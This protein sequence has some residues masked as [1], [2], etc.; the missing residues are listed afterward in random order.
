[1]DAPDPGATAV[2]PPDGP[3]D[4]DRVELLFEDYRDLT[5]KY[6]KLVWKT[7]PNSP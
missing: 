6:D 7:S 1:M 3:G 2:R 5:G 4:A